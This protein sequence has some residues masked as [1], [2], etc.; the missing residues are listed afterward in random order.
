MKITIDNLNQESQITI[1]K[2][3]LIYAHPEGHSNLELTECLYVLNSLVSLR[4]TNLQL[5]AFADAHLR[6]AQEIEN[7][8]RKKLV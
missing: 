1:E 6:L 7:V 3:K 2:A 5:L 8:R 4:L